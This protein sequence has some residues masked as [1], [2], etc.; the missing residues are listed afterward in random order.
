MGWNLIS[1]EAAGLSAEAKLHSASWCS[2]L[3]SE[4]FT[5]VTSLAAPKI[6]YVNLPWKRK[7][8]HVLAKLSA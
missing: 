8:S 2:S 7:F 3:A 5:G 4:L 6:N 1:G